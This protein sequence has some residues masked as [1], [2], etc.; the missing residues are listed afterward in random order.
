[1]CSIKKI[2]VLMHLIDVALA[3]CESQLKSLKALIID[4]YNKTSSKPDLLPINYE[5]LL[6]TDAWNRW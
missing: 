3:F 4:R 6:K 5:R 1:M 2:F